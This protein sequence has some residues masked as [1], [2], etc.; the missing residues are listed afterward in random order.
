M[1]S[2]WSLHLAAVCLGVNFF[3]PFSS[4]YSSIFA[5][6]LFWGV[7]FFE[8]EVIKFFSSFCCWSVSFTEYF[9][10]FIMQTL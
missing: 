10:F 6:V 9:C 8:V 1:F 4:R 7:F 3:S 2:L 5:C